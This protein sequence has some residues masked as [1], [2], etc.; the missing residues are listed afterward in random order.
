MRFIGKVQ[1]GWLRH[2]WDEGERVQSAHPDGSWVRL[3]QGEQT[4]LT[5]GDTALAEVLA[6]ATDR[7][8]TPLL[9]AACEA[10]AAAWLADPGIDDPGLEDLTA[11]PFVTIDY[12]TSMDL[13]QALF[14]A[15]EGDGHVVWYALADAAH[16]VRPGTALFDEA[17]RRG[18][19]YYLPGLTVPMLP[20]SLSEGLVSLLPHVDRRALVFRMHVDAHGACRRTEVTRARIH[21]VAKLAY[22]HVQ[23]WLDGGP[24]PTDHA[25]AQASLHA[26]VDVGERRLAEAESRHVIRVRRRE[27][28][29]T[30]GDF[31]TTFL[32]RTDLRNQVE[33]YSEQ[34][35]LMTNVEGARLLAHHDTPD[36]ELQPI[37]RTH[38]PPEPRRLAEL[39]QWIAQVVK[40]NQL[41]QSWCW[42]GPEAQSLANFLRDLP[43]DHPAAVA[44]H[45]QA[46]MIGGSSGFS[47]EPAAH[48]GVGADVYARFTA[49]MREV[50]GVFLHKELAEWRG[51]LPHATDDARRRD[52]VVEA[53]RRARN[54]Q[55]ALTSEINRR[56]LD[57]MLHEDLEARRHR[58]G[59]LLEV[60]SK[61]IRV[62]LDEPAIDV[63]AYVAHLEKRWGEIHTENEGTQL[64]DADGNKVL[65]VGARVDVSVDGLDPARNRWK[66]NVASID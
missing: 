34:I 18:A 38:A 62:Q 49:P 28:S 20:L 31:G 14:V 23:A 16:Y 43:H 7:G 26:L 32:A 29:V 15:P 19:T 39:Q 42:P 4:L 36:D 21:S 61:R 47:S 41:P 59:V 5:T 9:P 22:R 10:E 63:K 56:V 48:H 12:P 64:V 60:S 11:L 25:G 33:Q 55:R 1:D 27:V 13:D 46:L 37:Y 35:S 65:S 58:S 66:L 54:E 8:H 40:T 30:I 24:C 44:I 50:V 6:L 53:A 3:E 51:D 45:H 2:P 17:L 52:Q 57:R